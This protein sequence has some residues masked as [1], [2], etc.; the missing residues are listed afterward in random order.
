MTKAS[1]KTKGMKGGVR[2]PRGP[3]QTWSY[4]L[5]VGLQDAQRCDA[6]RK[7]FWVGPVRLEACPKCGSELRDTR[8]RR[9]FERSSFET[10]RDAELA[11][12]KELVKRGQG[13]Y[14]V[15]Q[16]ITL[17]TYLRDVFLPKLRGDGLKP[18]TLEG[19]ERHVH[20]HLIGPSQRPHR[21]GLMK[22][23]DLRLEAIREHY[24]MLGK[25][26]VAEHKGKLVDRQGLS[27]TSRRRVHAVLHRALNDAVEMGCLERNP[28][29]RAARKMEGDQ[30]RQH[31]LKCWTPD[32]LHRFLEATR[33][34]S[35]F[36]LWR[37]AAT[38]GARR[39]ELAALR[40]GD[41]NLDRR[42]DE[43]NLAGLM[44][45]RHNRVP[46]AGGRVHES[47]TKTGRVRVVE[48]DE[49]TTTVLRDLRSRRRGGEV[50]DLAQAKNEAESFVFTDDGGQPLNPNSIT[51][52]FR[53]AAKRANLPHIRF[54]DL[55]HT[56][57]SHLLEAGVNPRVVADRLGHAT[58]TMTLNVYAHVV[59]GR[60]A[61]AARLAAR[62]VEQGSF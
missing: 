30:E 1:D 27:P 6:C 58:T 39:G 59:R 57:G 35:L 2:R 56:H 22:L 25:G 53:L 47:T 43:G 18:V 48:L 15:P 51:W 62:V 16:T 26:Y 13:S 24:E 8:E 31:E 50:I 61:E 34:D 54:H 10:Q 12:A 60:Q 42:D 49:V 21:L 38:T 4:V 45:V 40:W 19:Y 37:L 7:R 14:V 36:P 44:T 28:A 17:A 3:G 55:R 11:R 9:V 20:D 52:Q 5:D 46:L 23:R 29:W 33:D 41:L 32:E